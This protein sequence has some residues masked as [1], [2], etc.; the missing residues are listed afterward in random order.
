[1]NHV[2][3]YAAASHGVTCIIVLLKLQPQ[4]WCSSGF[5]GINLEEGC[6]WYVNML[7]FC[8]SSSLGERV[9][10]EGKDTVRFLGSRGNREITFH[11]RKVSCS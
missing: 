9:Q 11:V 10:Q 7:T 8:S 3:N 6:K 2:S 5:V 1:M 4:I